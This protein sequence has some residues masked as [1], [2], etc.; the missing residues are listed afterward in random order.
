MAIF[1]TVHWR[2]ATALCLAL[3]FLAALTEPAGARTLGSRSALVPTASVPPF[4]GSSIESFD[5]NQSAPGAVT[6]VPDPV[7]SGEDVFKMTV[8]DGDVYPTTPTQDPRAELLSP[9]TIQ[10][11]DEFWWSSKFLLPRSFPA[12]VPGWVTV[13]EGPFGR[14]YYGIPPWHIEV[15]R[16]RIHWSRNRT[17]EWD[18]PWQTPLVRGRWIEV[19][20]HCKLAKRGFVEMWI[21]GRRVTFFRGDTYN[22]GHHAPTRRLR[23]R[24]LDTSNNRGPNY[25]SVLNYRKRGMFPSLTV[26]HG[27]LALGPTRDSVTP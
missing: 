27:P 2:I 22:P 24:T 19:L 26:L 11:G 17:Y 23:M 5:L 13:L 7:G 4:L 18:E 10:P 8:A 1:G 15:Q 20:V 25:V 16:G 12:S 9:R 21:D 3:A 6:E 14:P